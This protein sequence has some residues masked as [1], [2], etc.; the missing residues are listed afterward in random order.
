MRRSRF[1]EEQI[2]GMLKEHESGVWTANVCP[3]YAVSSAWF[4]TYTTKFGGM[5]V[6]DARELEALEMKTQGYCHEHHRINGHP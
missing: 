1:T 2:I 3:K 4:Y 6:S 5:D